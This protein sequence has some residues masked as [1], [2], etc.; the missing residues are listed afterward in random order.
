VRGAHAERR[1]ERSLETDGT[2]RRGERVSIACSGGPDSV[3]LAAVLQAAAKPMRLE[4]RLIHVNHGVRASA[5]QDECVATSVAA[6]LD[7][8]LEVVTLP[9]AQRDEAALREARYDA[10]AV[11]A[12]RSGSTVVATAHH[13]EDQTETVLLALFRGAGPN[14]FGGMRDRRP[15]APKVDLARP[16]LRVPSAELRRYCHARSLPYAV[17]PSNADLGLRRNAV[18][19]ALEGLRPSFPGLDQAV[20]RAAQ[21]AGDE[22]V[23]P[24]RAALRRRV[25]AR[26]ADEA[27]L[28]DVDFLHVEAAVR[29][30]ESGAS[31]SFHMK[32]GLRL[33]ILRG[34]IAGITRE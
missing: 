3:A 33:E 1:I 9:A 27:A 24:R 29:A 19:A 31:G 22:T 14:G 16:L 6:A 18:R 12:T 30:L 7:L 26:L 15:L 25:R 21:I 2:I 32:T 20:A 17:D 11:A 5:L 4:L 8:P 34:D 10:L 23:S 13:A 28:R